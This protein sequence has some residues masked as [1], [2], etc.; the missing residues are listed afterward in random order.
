MAVATEGIYTI[1]YTLSLHDALPISF[2]TAI[3]AYPLFVLFEVVCEYIQKYSL[4]L[5]LAI[6][7]VRLR[8]TLWRRR[9]AFRRLC[10][11]GRSPSQ[12]PVGF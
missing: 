12:L 6:Y 9:G 2:A 8:G 1:A 7:L 4:A 5:S 11:L 3:Y 10:E